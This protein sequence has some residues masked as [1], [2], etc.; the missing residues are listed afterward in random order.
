MATDEDLDASSKDAALAFKPELAFL[1]DVE[2]L[3]ESMVIRKELAGE[4]EFWN[5]E[6]E[7]ADIGLPLP[8]PPPPPPPPRFIPL[9]ESGEGVE[10]RG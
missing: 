3:P 1:P 2:P 10:A 6:A 7:Q 5:E 4:K 9:G 8:P